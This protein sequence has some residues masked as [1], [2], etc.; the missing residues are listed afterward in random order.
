MTVTGSEAD[1]NNGSEIYHM[2][3]TIL[4]A[5]RI[6]TNLILCSRKH[7]NFI[8]RGNGRRLNNLFKVVKR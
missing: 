1:D 6:S 7:T 3:G 2:S 5:S 4:S 8:N